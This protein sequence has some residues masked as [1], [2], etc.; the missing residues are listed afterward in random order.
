MK[1]PV[2]I[3]VMLL[4]YIT[5]ADSQQQS[6]AT[7]AISADAFVDSIGVNVH[8]HNADTPYGNFAAVREALQTLGVRHIRDGLIDTT[9]TA[10]Y[11]RLNELG[12]LGIKATLITSPKQNTALLVDYPKRV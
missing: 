8:L 11:N 9:W 2:L 7:T 3:V 1:C 4:C 10:Y 12:R 6:G 5:T